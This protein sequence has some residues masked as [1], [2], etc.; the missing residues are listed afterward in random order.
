MNEYSNKKYDSE[1]RTAKFGENTIE[2][3]TSL[4]QTAISKPII[5]QLVRSG[6]SVGAN[7]MEANGASSRKDF[8]NKIHLL[9]IH[10]KFKI[11]NLKL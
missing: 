11:D 5:N 7:Y 2:L 1:E 3:C 4:E 6:T 9:K 8:K 10:S